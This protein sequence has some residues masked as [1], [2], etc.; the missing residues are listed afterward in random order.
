[1]IWH[2]KMFIASMRFTRIGLCSGFATA[3]CCCVAILGTE[4]PVPYW[5]WRSLGSS[6]VYENS[7]CGYSDV[8]R[9]KNGTPRSWFAIE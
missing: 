6:R 8:R 3:P 9:S 2:Q 4:R 5:N 7:F 1:M